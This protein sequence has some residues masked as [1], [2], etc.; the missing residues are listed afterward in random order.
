[1]TYLFGLLLLLSPQNPSLDSV[2]PRE[3][4]D[5]IEKMAVPGN[6]DAI[7]PLTAAL[8]KESKSDL[9]AE[10]VA[11]FGRIRDR[12]AVPVLADTLRNDLDRGVRSQAIDSI[13]RVYIPIDETGAIRTIFNKVK[14]V[15]LQ[16]NAPVVGPEVQVDA[17]AK[18]ALA[19]AMQKDF[20]DEVR[21]QAARA[22]AS[23][24]AR[25]QVPA[26][27][28][29]LEDPQNREHRLVRIEIARTLGLL[30]ESAAGP[31]LERT[32]RDSDRE[33]VAEAA[34]SIG[35]VGYSNARPALE[36]TY[37]TS[38]SGTV[39]SHSLEGLALLR[40]RASVPLF[41]SLLSNQNEN[42]RQLAAEGLARLNYDGAKDWKTRLDQ[43]KKVNVRLALA[44]GLV[45]S[46][47]TGYFDELANALDSRQSNQAEAYIFELG[48]Y[49]GKLSELHR[50]LRSS[51]PRVRAGMARIVGN[52]GDP[53]SAD[54]IRPLTDDPNTDVVREAVSALRKLTR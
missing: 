45:T 30:R 37:R 16:P 53:S 42:Y 32:L 19:T 7:A 26:L 36:Q 38:S 27:M 22:L 6:K 21:A 31:A 41:E 2:S 15:F 49:G 50:Y 54:Q 52:V 17:A 1:V 20:D 10:I 43:E 40:D 34:L 48:K 29:A 44:Y 47:D 35:L 8:K 33:L 9:R 25:D 3:R 46:G 5:A 24:R 28:A 18:E 13:L 14:S 4:E 23:L 12:S 51:N 39:K 11:A